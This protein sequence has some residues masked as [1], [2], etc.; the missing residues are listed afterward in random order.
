MCIPLKPV[1]SRHE[2]DGVQIT[3]EP[4]GALDSKS[5]R[6]L[7]ESLL[8]MN[9]RSHATILMVTHDAF[10]ASF[11]RR[12]LF[13]RDGRIF[14]ELLRGEETRQAFFDRIMEVLSLLGGDLDVG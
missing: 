1:F 5:A 7:L 14:N 10:A 3:D 8:E 4:T 6:M 11:C 13:L 2:G 9:E 12:I